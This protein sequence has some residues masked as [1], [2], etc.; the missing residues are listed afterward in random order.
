VTSKKSTKTRKAN[1]KEEKF[2][3]KLLTRLK[4]EKHILKTLWKALDKHLQ[5]LNHAY[6]KKDHNQVKAWKKLANITQFS[7]MKTSS[8]TPSEKHTFS[9]PR[10]KVA[11]GF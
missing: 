5:V 3:T 8:I 11:L 2:E 6:T 9:S 10:S 1:S 7:S 4:Q